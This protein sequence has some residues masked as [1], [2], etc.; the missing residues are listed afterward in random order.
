MCDREP[1]KIHADGGDEGVTAG[2][3]MGCIGL[4][5]LGFIEEFGTGAVVKA[6]AIFQS[7]CEECMDQ[8]FTGWRGVMM[9]FFFLQ[10]KLDFVP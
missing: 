10:K 2:E 5:I 1:E 6:A 3:E 8:S 9:V 4:Y 7:G